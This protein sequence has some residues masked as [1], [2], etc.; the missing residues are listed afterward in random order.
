MLTT[1]NLDKVV[2]VDPETKA[3]NTTAA[4][5]NSIETIQIEALDALRSSLAKGSPGLAQSLRPEIERL[6]SSGLVSVRNQ[7]NELA[8]ALGEPAKAR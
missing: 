7:A 5:E 3:Q 6:T 1:A 2:H 4:R 8:H